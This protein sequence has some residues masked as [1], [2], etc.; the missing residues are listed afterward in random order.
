MAFRVEITKAAE[1]QLEELYLWVVPQAP[2]Q[3]A[4]WFNS[5]ERAILSLD[6][7]PERCTVAPESLDP[8]HPIRVLLYG[9][10][11]HV[12]RVFF[13]IDSNKNLVSVLHVRRGSRSSANRGD[14]EGA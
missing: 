1:V 9:R 7:H 5:L 12:Y 14:L 3:G 10:R 13:T 8:E 11:S 6:Q 4:D 2:R